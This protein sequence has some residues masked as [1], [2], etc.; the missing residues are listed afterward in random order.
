MITRSTTIISDYDCDDH[1]DDDDDSS[2]MYIIRAMLTFIDDD[3]GLTALQAP[4]R[5]NRQALVSSMSEPEDILVI[6]N[7]YLGTFYLLAT[8]CCGKEKFRHQNCLQR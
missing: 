4:S 3:I 2:M 7:F 1:D 6:F 8:N 5:W